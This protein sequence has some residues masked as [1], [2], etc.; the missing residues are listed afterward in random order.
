MEDKKIDAYINGKIEIEDTFLALLQED[1]NEEG[2]NESLNNLNLHFQN[3]G[4]SQNQEE[5][6]IFLY[7]ISKIADNHNRTKEFFKKIGEVLNLIHNEIKTFLSNFDIFDIF[8]SNPR[9]LLSLLQNNLLEADEIIF[10]YMMKYYYEKKRDQYFAFLYPE[11]KEFLSQEDVLYYEEKISN[12]KQYEIYRQ[13]GENENYFCSLIRNDLIDEF[14]EFSTRVNLQ[15]SSPVP[16]SLFESNPFL[17]DKE[18]TL[19]EYAAFYGSI[20]IFQ[21]LRLQEVTLTPSLWLYA[22]HSNNP[23]IIHLLEEL[24]VNP[25]DSTFY[26]CFKE[27]IICHHNDVANY[28]KECKIT[29]YDENYLLESQYDWQKRKS[30]HEH[31]FDYYNFHFMNIKSYDKQ[32]LYYLINFDYVNLIKLYLPEEFEQLDQ[33]VANDSFFNGLNNLV[34]TSNLLNLNKYIFPNTVTICSSVKKMSKFA[35]LDC[36]G[37]RNVF[38]ECPSSISQIGPSSFL[39]CQYL[40][41][42]SIPPSVTQIGNTCFLKCKHLVHVYIPSS[43]TYIGKSAFRGCSSLDKISIPPLIKKIDEETFSGCSSLTQVIFESPSSLASIEYCAFKD[44]TS[45]TQI[46]IPSSLTRFGNS[47][48]IGCSSLKQI[49]IPSSVT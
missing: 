32:I 5:L 35:F 24:Q 34:I 11:F 49:L 44:C 6:K 15:L 31:I 39:E 48:F 20:K 41:Q 18:T 43:V 19:I 42:I 23:E 1:I 2:F 46:S 16:F 9:M 27:A 37:I 17:F 40:F 7:Y 10:K 26:E 47:V 22:I 12:I 45:L 30:I 13:E 36:S 33:I 28:I 21:Y 25:K 38:F 29:R 14:V 3:Q 4:F 8:K